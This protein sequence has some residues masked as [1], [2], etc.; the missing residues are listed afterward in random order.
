MI[1][2]TESSN[3]GRLLVVCG[4][5]ATGKT[6]LGVY[7]A[8]LFN[9]EIISADSRQ[10]YRKMD[11]GTGK[12]IEPG[13]VIKKI[14]PKLQYYEIDGVRVFGYDLVNA[15]AEYSVSQYMDFAC[16]AIHSMWSRKK[17]PIIVGGT[18]LYIK[19][20]VDGIPTIDVPRNDNLRQ[21]LENLSTEQMYESL[22]QIDSIRAGSMNASDKKNPRRLMRAIEIA[23]FLIDN[24]MPQTHCLE[25]NTNILFVGLTAPQKYLEDKIS[26]RVD[27][28]ATNGFD[29]EVQFLLKSGVSWKN[30]SMASLG[31]RQWREFLEKN[32]PKNEAILEWKK[33][34][35]KYAKRQLTWFRRDKRINWFDVSTIKYLQNVENMVKKWHNS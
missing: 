2:I 21:K 20:V 1:L 5:T 16:E 30:Q 11:I 32:I 24:S 34:E 33:E 13:S 9:G 35:K 25:K 27:T 4:P 31:Y 14:N 3:K 8:K 10:V 29:A 23:Q 28:R 7:L 17:L 22:S 12:D 15:D 19:A 18:G 6:A 26:I